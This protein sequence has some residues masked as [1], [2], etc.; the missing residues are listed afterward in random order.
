MSKRITYE[1]FEE[2]VRNRPQP[3]TPGFYK[4]WRLRCKATDYER[5]EV[6]GESLNYKIPYKGFLWRFPIKD[7]H[8]MEFVYYP[9]FEEAYRAMMD[10]EVV[11]NSIVYSNSQQEYTF[12]YHI[13]RLG[14]GPH[15]TRDFYIQ[16]WKYDSN[17]VEYDRS[18]CSSYHFN[19]PGIYGK[20]LGRFPKNIRFQEGDIVEISVSRFEDAGKC[21]STLGIVIGTPRT[22]RQQ[23]E[24]EEAGINE[25]A[26]KGAP[27][28]IEKYFEKPDCWGVDIEEY[29]ILYGPYEES[30]RFATFEHPQEVRPPSFDVPEEA[31]ETLMKYYNE[32]QE[33][34]K[35]D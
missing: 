27:N 19:M 5:H 26:E 16:Y 4:L 6:K 17:Q 24:W 12:G 14:F 21:Y 11:D 18:S 8:H 10:N 31:K 2:F 3:D 9:T 32:Y 25:L 23:W 22:V 33:S 1:E 20:F 13:S 15:G 29:F 35:N 30:M 28:P 34:L 7:W